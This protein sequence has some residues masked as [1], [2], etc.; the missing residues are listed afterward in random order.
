MAA[1]KREPIRERELTGMKYLGRIS[2]LLERLRPVGCERERDGNRKLCF[3]QYCSLILL[4]LFNP[5]VT[6]T[7][8]EHPDHRVRRVVVKV[9]VHPKRGGR[10]RTAAI[11]DIVLA[12]NLLDVPAEVIALIYR[13]RW[14]I[15]LFFR[16]LK[17]VLGC[18]HL[19]SRHSN[20]IEIQSYC[21]IIACLLISLTTGKKAT[22]RTYE[23]LCY[24]FMGLA[25]EDE[26]LAHLNRLPP[27]E[28]T[29]H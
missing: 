7:R 13:C 10:K 23:M 3:D 9:E 28:K 26:L 18:R 5:V 12:T 14:M 19:L 15:E 22:L 6:S 21:A 24:D 4:Y 20:G 11:K 8:I 2:S 27:H 29:C 25:H 17:H 16:F 1:R